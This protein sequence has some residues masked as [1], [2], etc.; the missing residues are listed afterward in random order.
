MPQ[1][2][3]SLSI[4]KP[5]GTPTKIPEALTR[6][7]VAK[8]PPVPI[9]CVTTVSAAQ[10]AVLPDVGRESGGLTTKGL[11]ESVPTPSSGPPGLPTLAC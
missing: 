11:I 10:G 2:S 6:E 4:M 8:V 7:D 9:L 5:S 1:N 3:N